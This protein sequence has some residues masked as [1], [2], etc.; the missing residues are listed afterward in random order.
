MSVEEMNFYFAL[1]MGMFEILAEFI[2]NK[3]GNDE[4]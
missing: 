1:G 3:E 4:E 2:Y